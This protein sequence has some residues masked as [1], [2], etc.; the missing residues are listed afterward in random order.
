M[1]PSRARPPGARARCSGWLDC[2]PRGLRDGHP[3]PGPPPLPPAFL[4]GPGLGPA[5]ADHPAR[6]LCGFDPV[7]YVAAVWAG[8]VEGSTKVLPVGP[9]CTAMP[10]TLWFSSCFQV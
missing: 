2:S 8:T 9:V 5:S 1:A 4:A 3:V 6:K 10:V 7:R